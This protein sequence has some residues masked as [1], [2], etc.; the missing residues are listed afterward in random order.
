MKALA[1]NTQTVVSELR[2]ANQVSVGGEVCKDE[3]ECCLLWAQAV[4]I[5]ELGL[6]VFT[7]VVLVVYYVHSMFT[8]V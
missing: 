8:Q 3:R 5:H 1:E 7:G 2:L 6:H 4:Y